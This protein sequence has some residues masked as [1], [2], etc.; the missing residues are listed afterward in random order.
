MCEFIS[1]YRIKKPAAS[2]FNDFDAL[3]TEN[4]SYFRINFHFP[5]C[6]KFSFLHKRL[7]ELHAKQVPETLLGL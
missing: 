1:F 6:T 5:Y 2:V 4:S 7:I 3:H